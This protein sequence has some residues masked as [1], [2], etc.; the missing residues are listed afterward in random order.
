MVRAYPTEPS[1]FGTVA[2]SSTEVAKLTIHSCFVMVTDRLRWSIS[3]FGTRER[4]TWR[5]RVSARAKISLCISCLM[6]HTPSQRCCR[7]YR[8]LSRY[9]YIVVQQNCRR[10]CLA[11]PRLARSVELS[12]VVRAKND[13]ANDALKGA[14]SGC[15]YN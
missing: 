11:N 1:H 14:A 9:L 7:D 8:A 15:Y 4:H 5:H 3:C 6:A 12:T 10:V 2:L 13:D